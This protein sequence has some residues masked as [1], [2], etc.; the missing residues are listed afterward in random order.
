MGVSWVSGVVA[1]D[2]AGVR[3][4]QKYSS[5]YLVCAHLSLWGARTH[6]HTHTHT[7]FLAPLRRLKKGTRPKMTR[8]RP[9]SA[10]EALPYPCTYPYSTY[11]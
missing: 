10:G 3:G 8:W 9:L 6:T 11:Y 2:S 7:H 4:L 5:Q 1:V